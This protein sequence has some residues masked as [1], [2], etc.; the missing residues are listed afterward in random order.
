MCKL[1][2]KYA[3]EKGFTVIEE[4]RFTTSEGLRKPDLLVFNNEEAAIIEVTITG[5]TYRR[6]GIVKELKD[7]YNDKL[8]Y[9][10]K[11]E[12]LNSAR[13]ISG[14]E[15]RV[16]PFVLSVRGVWLSANADVLKFLKCSSAKTVLELRSL[17][18]SLRIWQTFMH[19]T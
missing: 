12:I 13:E 18:G 3:S 17:E 19:T 1:I 5:E 6:E 10:R 8:E 2:R 7:Q 15:T 14:H 11:E 9:Y 4:P 16:L